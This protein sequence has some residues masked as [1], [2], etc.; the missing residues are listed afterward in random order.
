M[1]N[2]EMTCTDANV[3]LIY[4]D[5]NNHTGW[6]CPKCGRAISPDYSICPYCSEQ[7]KTMEGLQPGEQL[8]LD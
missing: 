8:I 1:E 6:V 4:E 3:Q 7:N 2:V 5:M